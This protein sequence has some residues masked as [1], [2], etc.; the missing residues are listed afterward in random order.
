MLMADYLL[1]LTVAGGA[2]AGAALEAAAGGRFDNCSNPLS[3]GA[4]AGGVVAGAED[5]ASEGPLP[6]LNF[7]ANNEALLSGLYAATHAI[8]IASTKNMP[9]TYLVIL[10]STLPEPAPKS[11]SVAAPP[12]AVPPRP[13]SF[14]GNC[15]NTR[16]I[17]STQS[18]NIKTVKV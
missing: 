5:G 9:A 1:V 10:V 12:K 8:K 13:A 16:K 18:R 7:F 6:W 14:L 2:E 4:V 17:S 11:A 3:A 15:S